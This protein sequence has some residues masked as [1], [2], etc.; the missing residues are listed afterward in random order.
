MDAE[1]YTDSSCKKRLRLLLPRLPAHI[2][3]TKRFNGEAESAAEVSAADTIFDVY[4]LR[5]SKC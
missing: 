3:L 4:W 2:S 1:Q 5:T